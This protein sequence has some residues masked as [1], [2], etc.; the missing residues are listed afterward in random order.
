MRRWGSERPSDDHDEE[1]AIRVVARVRPLTE[2][3]ESSGHAV[4]LSCLDDARTVQIEMQ[5]SEKGNRIA[6]SFCLDASIPPE[7]SQGVFFDRS[8]IKP[9]LHSVLDGFAATCFAYGQTGSGK[10]F[11]LVGPESSTDKLDQRSS[12][13]DGLLSRAV[14]FIF[15]EIKRREGE[16][17]VEVSYCEIYNEQV[18]DL[19]AEGAAAGTQPLPVRYNP[20]QGFYVQGL[21]TA[22]CQSKAEV[23]RWFCKGFKTTRVASHD[24]NTRSNRSHCIFNIHVHIKTTDPHQGSSQV[25]HGKMCFVDLAGSERERD[26]GAKG[27]VLVESG[28]I[29]KSLFVLG[30]VIS[31]LTARARKGR[32]SSSSERVPYRDSILTRLLMSSLGGHCKTLM[33]TC[34]SA[35]AIHVSESVRSLAFAAQAKHIRNKPVIILDPKESLIQVCFFLFLK[36]AGTSSLRPHTL[37]A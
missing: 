35:S 26:T 9:L 36:L 1:E 37:A 14:K 11:S 22:A 13:Q 8:G 7:A 16:H 34:C 3:E 21:R 31:A 4:A 12:E 6:Q 2:A 33:V 32:D 10:T 27:K 17:V 23:M 28:H 5:A 19:L 15:S 20:H 30:K 25:A 29:N 18:R 24:M